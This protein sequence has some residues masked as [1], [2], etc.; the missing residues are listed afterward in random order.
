[1]ETRQNGPR[2]ATCSLPRSMQR[3]STRSPNYYIYLQEACTDAAAD[4][5]GPWQPTAR[6]CELTWLTLKQAF[7]DEYHVTHG[8]IAKL[9]KTPQYEAESYR[10]LRT[11][12]DAG[13]G[14]MRQLR[15]VC[16]PLFLLEQFAIHVF[17]RLSPRATNDAWEQHRSRQGECYLP[18]FDEY[19]SFLDTRAKGRKEFDDDVSTALQTS[20][21]HSRREAES[22]RDKSRFKP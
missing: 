10:S 4:T 3:S 18:T 6:N 14:G 21:D 2:F 20:G 5:L 13:R 11:L 15:A 19:M 1:M 12:V 16:D 22:T 17:R 8:M 9:Y 7:G